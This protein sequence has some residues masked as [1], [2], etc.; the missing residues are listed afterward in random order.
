M[1]GFAFPDT[2]MMFWRNVKLILWVFQ[3]TIEATV[4]EVLQI[5]F[6]LSGNT[7]T[8]KAL[9]EV[10]IS[11]QKQLFSKEKERKKKK[12]MTEKD[13]GFKSSLISGSFAEDIA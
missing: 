2:Q 11:I 6:Q 7:V 8:L 9:K 13:N 12:R 3:K 4:E 10:G 5:C 1:V